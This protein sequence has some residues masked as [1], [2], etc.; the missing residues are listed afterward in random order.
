MSKNLGVVCVLGILLSLGASV[1]AQ[2]WSVSAGANSSAKG[3]IRPS[4]ANRYEAILLEM[5]PILQKS[6]GLT[7][8]VYLSEEEGERASADAATGQIYF[9]KKIFD[10]LEG[11][12]GAKINYP[13]PKSDPIPIGIKFILAHEY[14]H[15][16]QFLMFK[17]K[18]IA[19]AAS[20]PVD[21]LQADIL[22]GYALSSYFYN[23]FSD[24]PEQKRVNRVWD[25]ISNAV[26]VVSNLGDNFFMDKDHH[27]NSY[28]R[29]ECLMYGF[30]AVVKN[31]FEPRT[32]MIVSRPDEIYNWS[33]CLAE[34]TFNNQHNSKFF[35]A[36]EV[37]PKRKC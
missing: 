30:Y 23:K 12:L 15:Q 19:L 3:T 5:E 17:R 28:S 4:S 36:Q 6:M 21:E 9:G 7:S 35:N 24:L 22:A 1:R 26:F 29:T 27:G 32:M 20:K 31:Q 34:E 33:R 18:K 2:C 37:I 11:K 8:K 16:F 14:A 13:N 10:Y 25:E